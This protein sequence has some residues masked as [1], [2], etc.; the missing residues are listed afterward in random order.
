MHLHGWSNHN[1]NE[2]PGSMQWHT[3][4]ARALPLDVIW[5]TDHLAWFGAPKPHTIDLSPG[6][7]DPV[8]LNVVGLPT[9]PGGQPWLPGYMMA[10]VSGG[11]ATASLSGG[12]LSWRLSNNEPGFATF[13][14]APR[15]RLDPPTPPHSTWYDPALDSRSH[16][17]FDLARGPVSNDALVAVLVKL[18]WHYYSAALQQTLL[19]RFVPEGVPA[20]REV[21]G[22][23]Q[24]LVTV[25][26]GETRQKVDL[27]L[28]TDALL[29]PDG[30][31]NAV[32]DVSFIAQ[33]RNRATVSP[34][35]GYFDFLT[36]SPRTDGTYRGCQQVA[37]GYTRTRGVTEY[38]GFEA[39]SLR[40]VEVRSHH[41][42]V[43]WA[44]PS[45]DL[46][47][48]P[49]GGA[50]Y[51][52][53]VS[54]VHQ[55]GG[56][57]A[58]CHPFGIGKSAGLPMSQG[59]RVTELVNNLLP[60]RCFGTDMIEVGYNWRAGVNLAHHLEMWDRL[61]ANGLTVCGTGASDAHGGWWSST[62]GPNPNAT[63][64]W[65]R[66]KGCH[67]LLDGLRQRRVYFGNPFLYEGVLD[68]SLG[69][70]VMGEA[71]VVSG[72]RADLHVTLQPLPAGTVVLVQGL[73]QP[74]RPMRYLRKDTIDPTHPITLDTSRPC[75]LRVEAYARD[76][77]F[78]VA[79][80]P[81]V[82]LKKPRIE[83]AEPVTQIPP[84]ESV[85][86][87]WRVAGAPTQTAVRWWVS[88]ASGGPFVIGQPVDSEYEATLATSAL[89]A[90]TTVCYRIHATGPDWSVIFPVR[91]QPPLQV[92]ITPGSPSPA[93]G[94]VVSQLAANPTR[95]GAEITLRLSGA[96][97]VSVEVLNLAGHHVATVSR[98]LLC[99]AGVSRLP[100]DRRGDTGVRVPS[101]RYLVRAAATV[102]GGLSHTALSALRL[103]P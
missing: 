27:D 38:V 4:F 22:G 20:R 55:Q 81:I 93:V 72:D 98:G 14:Y 80:N 89:A 12:M 10:S 6:H 8:T 53:I 60:Y 11:T 73:I 42:T 41:Y 33:S 36:D 85:R 58:Y 5:W 97:T 52:T 62:M 74:G 2:F 75:F 45:A 40:T 91:A 23:T 102:P 7:I 69:S 13:S 70:L 76:G 47:S 99:P 78:L 65:A 28:R 66:S 48:W 83:P 43:F 88:G 77:Q 26:V 50:P 30:D 9:A 19:Y 71:G 79:S 82:V 35:M 96:A 17:I 68:L 46:P 3:H 103:G 56:L 25:P 15:F 49:D 16:L 34:Q 64:V 51:S 24:V 44:S 63:W 39:A 1:G 57:V 92:A 32:Q 31:D 94:I 87:R 101:G 90:G 59:Q 67:D 29:L 37:E 100:W 21:I 84:G 61:N 86:V 18:S 95:T 54:D